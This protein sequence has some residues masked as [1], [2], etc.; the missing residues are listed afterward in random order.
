MNL[1]TLKQR[2][3]AFDYLF[4]AVVVTDL[5]GV[6][7]DWN[8]GSEELYG[9]SKNEAIGQPVN[10]L[11]VPED[12]EKI[13]LE[14]IS[15]VEKFGKWSGEIRMLRKNGDIGWIESM[16]VPIYADNEQMIGALG[17][18]RDITDRIKETKRLEQLAHY[19]YLTKIPNRYLLIDRIEHLIAQ[20]ERSKNHFALLFIDLDDFKVIND[21]KG[22]T[23]G[24]QV[25]VETASRLEKT[26]R[27]SDTVGRIGGDE[28]VLLLEN[29]S[30]K[31]DLSS[32]VETIENK[33]NEVF[34]FD[35]KQLQVSC[36]IGVA[37]YPE[38]GTTMDSLL[39]AADVDMYK[40]KGKRACS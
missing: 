13:T 26:I 30:N 2:A 24:D 10:I 1:D 19:D 28:F 6:I 37:I 35:D 4:D 7:I 15:A 5:Q 21:T 33:L 23:F 8:K 11:H 38:D 16:C 40:A 31:N 32:M 22:H 20:S 25:L 27:K 29:I 14:V 3:K 12:S 9:Y 18:N 17:I 34:I 36:S 39:T